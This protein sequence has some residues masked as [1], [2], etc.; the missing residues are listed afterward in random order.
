MSLYKWLVRVLV[1]G[2]SKKVPFVN[3]NEVNALYEVKL[4]EL[5]TKD[6]KAK[7]TK[8]QKQ[9]LLDTAKDLE[10]EITEERQPESTDSSKE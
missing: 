1:L 2:A 9:Q 6:K 3:F 4:S 10:I 7:K 5:A 8:D